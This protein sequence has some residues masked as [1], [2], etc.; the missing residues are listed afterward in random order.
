MIVPEPA[1]ARVQVDAAALQSHPPAHPARGRR[2]PDPSALM[3]SAPCAIVLPSPLIVP[4]GERR[5]A[6]HRDVAC[7]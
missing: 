3:V 2:Q 5:R 4:A 1:A 7:R 6:A